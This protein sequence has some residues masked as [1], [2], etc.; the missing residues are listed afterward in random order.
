MAVLI[1]E[2]EG[3]CFRI[4]S[5]ALL[6]LSSGMQWRPGTTFENEAMLC[7][8]KHDCATTIPQIKVLAPALKQIVLNQARSCIPL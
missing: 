2:K 6:S 8:S 1:L 3:F 5:S 7:F 4:R